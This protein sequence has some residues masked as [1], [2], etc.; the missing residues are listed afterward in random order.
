VSSP[1]LRKGLVDTPILVD[2]RA[3]EPAAVQFMMDL[4]HRTGLINLSQ[5]SGLVMLARCQTTAERDQLLHGFLRNSRVH[6]VSAQISHRAFRIMSRVPSPSPLSADDA[7]VAATAVVHK[8]PL[9]TLDPARFAA[10]PGL[11][12][13][14]PY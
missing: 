10:V 9:Y 13:L 14:Q 2:S 3:G 4:L 12:V 8:L 7:V 6:A 11:A 5:L 1:G